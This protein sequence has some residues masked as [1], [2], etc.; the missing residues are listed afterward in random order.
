MVHEQRAARREFLLDDRG[1][2]A[3]ERPEGLA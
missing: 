1:A 3:G 2:A